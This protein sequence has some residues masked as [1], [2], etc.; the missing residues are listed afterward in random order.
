MDMMTGKQLY[1]KINRILADRDL[2]LTLFE[3]DPSLTAE[4]G[5]AIEEDADHRINEL[6]FREGTPL[7]IVNGQPCYSLGEK[8]AIEAGEDYDYDY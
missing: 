6:C 7:Y 2:K 3:L 4:H 5:I 8:L 1:H